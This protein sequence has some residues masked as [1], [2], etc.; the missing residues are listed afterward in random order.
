MESR[1]DDEDAPLNLLT[2]P[3]PH[4]HTHTTQAFL[5]TSINGSEG[6]VSRPGRSTPWGMVLDIHRPTQ[7]V[8]TQRR[9]EAELPI[10]AYLPQGQG[11]RLF[12]GCGPV[13]AIAE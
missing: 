8:W 11:G 9:R 2:Y 10:P 5:T 4:T 7:L 1:S 13:E 3:L 6:S 12:S